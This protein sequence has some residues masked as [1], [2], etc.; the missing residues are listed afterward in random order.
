MKKKK[1]KKWHWVWNR[2]CKRVTSAIAAI[3]VGKVYVWAG[4]WKNEKK[5]EKKP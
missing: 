3:A 4:E 5:N 1:K 2:N